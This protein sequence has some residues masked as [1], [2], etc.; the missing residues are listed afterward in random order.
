LLLRLAFGLQIDHGPALILFSIPIVVSAYMGGPG[1]GITATLTSVLLA[2]YWLLSPLH[3]FRVASPLHQ[4]DLLTMLITGTAISLITGK[5]HSSLRVVRF[6]QMRLSAIL[7]SAMDAIITVDEQQRVLLFNSAAENMFSC[8]AAD[9]MGSSI[10]RFIPERLREKHAEHVRE[11][12]HSSESSRKM[13]RNPVLGLRSTGDE[14]PIEAS[15][16]QVRVSG[17]HLFSVTL[18]DVTERE[19][20]EE[21][22]RQ[23]E[24]RFSLAFR[25]NPLAMTIAIQKDGRY[26]DCNDA[27]LA[28]TGWGRSAVIGC[29]ASELSL[30][31]DGEQR[32]KIVGQLV[33][34]DR[35]LA[36]RLVGIPVKFKTAAGEVREGTVSAEQIDIGDVHC[37][38]ELIQD[39]TETKRLERQFYQSQKMEA[40]GR[41]AAWVGHDLNNILSVILG[42]CELG[43][44]QFEA[45]HPAA[46]NLVQI[47]RA[48]ERAS[49][50]TRQLLAFSRQQMIQPR[51]LNLNEVIHS[52][53]TML[54]R[55]IGEDVVL[56]FIPTEPLGSILADVGQVEQVLMNLVVNA[57]D[58]MPA[59]GSIIIETRETELDENYARRHAAAI[60]GPYVMLS[61]TDTGCG[62]DESTKSRIFEPFFTTKEVGKGTGLGLSTVY[63]VVKQHGGYVWVY[64]EVGK[65]TTF[66]VY[67]PRLSNEPESLG[68]RAEKDAVG[69]SE[70]ILVVEDEEELRKVTGT[71]LESAGYKVLQAESPQQALALVR[72][73]GAAIDLLLTDVVM[74]KMSGVELSS[75]VRQAHP[76]VKLL[77]MSGYAG[78]LVAQHGLDRSKTQLIEKPFTRAKLLRK[79]REVLDEKGKP[80]S[81]A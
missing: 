20:A 54:S 26:L 78:E 5:L 45:A 37:V 33:N 40:V 47:R 18:R 49:S 12:A 66:K 46:H 63:G 15:I 62:M 19:R 13:S 1:P 53:T 55:M 31:E 68:P 80:V 44:N 59:G 70:T 75:Q 58:A 76:S 21:A 67:F 51:V 74:P 9:A 24:E 50:L 11:F 41:L 25:S 77:Y 52:L 4:L 38:L 22:L 10:G 48:A 35:I 32:E 23:S 71:L 42:H 57:R 7:N 2:A 8:T 60:P 79:L 27:F 56:S 6:V 30:W 43:R 34:S 17:E 72:K 73:Y 3:S 29:T 36:D 81:T 61:V 28:M 39:L 64:S 16:S 69:G 65:G 14:F